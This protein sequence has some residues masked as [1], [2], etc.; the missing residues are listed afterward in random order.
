M[1]LTTQSQPDL[2][3]NLDN[4]IN[5]S[6]SLFNFMLN[7]AK[8]REDLESSWFVI[9]QDIDLADAQDQHRKHINDVN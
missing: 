8:T 2:E 9:S 7:T 6:H 5:I 1:G 4:Q 3:E